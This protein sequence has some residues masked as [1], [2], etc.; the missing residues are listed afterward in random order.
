MREGVAFGVPRERAL[1]E[2]V[3][4]AAPRGVFFAGPDGRRGALPFVVA[5]AFTLAEARPES[6]VFALPEFFSAMVP[7]V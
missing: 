1:A 7:R 6:F 3:F 5:A 4:A 2:D